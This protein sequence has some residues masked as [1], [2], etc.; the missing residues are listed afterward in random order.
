[1]KE[2]VSPSWLHGQDLSFKN[3][4]SVFEVLK[5]NIEDAIAEQKRELARAV[6]ARDSLKK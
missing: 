4:S 3:V 2:P 1:M 6:G 5:E